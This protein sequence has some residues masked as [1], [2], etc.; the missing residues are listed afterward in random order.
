M[1]SL[2]T[3]IISIALVVALAV[4]TLQT[5]EQQF[6][7]GA[8]QMRRA[9]QV[10]DAQPAQSGRGDAQF[11]PA[12]AASSLLDQSQ[13]IL[14]AATLY[15]NEHSGSYPTDIKDLMNG[16]YLD[17]NTLPDMR[18]S[19]DTF[20]MATGSEGFYVWLK[21]DDRDVCQSISASSARSYGPNSTSRAAYDCVMQGSAMTFSFRG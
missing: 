21:L 8:A 13:V 11:D 18:V 5:G 14:G 6:S 20:H 19:K 2:I 4:A 1:F 9:Q 15:A 17:S 3:T 12:A 16:R 10:A 7:N